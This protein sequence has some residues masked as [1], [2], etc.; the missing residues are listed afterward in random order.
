MSGESGAGA[1]PEALH[2]TLQRGTHQNQPLN[3]VQMSTEIKPHV[4][5]SL[6]LLLL[7]TP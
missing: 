5:S 6:M 1:D 4:G 3:G 2:P 7:E